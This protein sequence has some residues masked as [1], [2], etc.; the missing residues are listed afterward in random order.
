MTDTHSVGPNMIQS[1][2]SKSLGCSFVVI[3]NMLKAAKL[4]KLPV[5]HHILLCSR[6]SVG[7][8]LLVVALGV[9]LSSSCHSFILI[10]ATHY[11]ITVSVTI[12]CCQL[13]IYIDRV[14]SFYLCLI[15]K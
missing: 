6:L 8:T 13:F 11:P 2:G 3:K 15:L 14:T 1:K 12:T 4:F 5:I 7:G 10:T 9:M